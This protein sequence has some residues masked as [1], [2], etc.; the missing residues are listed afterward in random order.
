MVRAKKIA[1][2]VCD[3]MKSKTKNQSN[4]CTGFTLLEVL[5]ASVL[6]L[7]LIEMI[8]QNY[9]SAKKIYRVQNEITHLS[10]DI[11][12]ANYF[13]QKNIM[14]AGFAG[15][16]RISELKPTNHT[17]IKFEVSDVVRGYDSNS[18]QMLADLPE[19]K[20][21]VIP[22]TDVIVITKANTGITKIVKDIANNETSIKVEEN[23]ATET[24]RFLLISDCKKAD[25]F[26]AKNWKGE[27]IIKFED[28]LKHPYLQNE[29]FVSQVER[30]A[31]FISKIDYYSPQKPPVYSL[32]Y[33]INHGYKQELIPEISNMQIEYGV[34][35]RGNNKVTEILKAAEI[36]N[37]NLWNR[38]LSV[39][40][41]LTPQNRL[42]GLKPWKIYIKLRER[43]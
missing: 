39:A 17:D 27:K 20:G 35:V 1:N 32:Y 23:P 22:G 31:F 14:H 6:G 37:R 25:L 13:L 19:L 16:R 40:I 11:R 21:K 7:A 34:D 3:I 24:N 2:S 41:T 9:S 29:T 28:E 10:E 5:I 36:T 12:F 30:I 15:C 38:V 8:L 33:L 18:T 42:P 26:I 43:G 4:F